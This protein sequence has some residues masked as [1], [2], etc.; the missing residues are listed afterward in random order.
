MADGI[1]W[2]ALP[3]DGPA[4]YWDEN[5]E[6]HPEDGSLGS[7]VA[8]LTGLSREKIDQLGGAGEWKD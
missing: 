5:G 8:A 3:G 7:S 2:R 6:Q 1:T 4:P